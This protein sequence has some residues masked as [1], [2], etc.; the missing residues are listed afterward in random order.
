MIMNKD[1]IDKCDVILDASDP[2]FAEQFREAIG[3]A[4]GETIEMGIIYLT[5]S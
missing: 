5:P 4:P 3:A 2:D 1:I